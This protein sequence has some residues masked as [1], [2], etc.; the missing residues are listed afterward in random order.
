[1]QACYN[2]T[3]M[4]AHRHVVIKINTYFKGSN[5]LQYGCISIDS[6]MVMPNGRPVQLTVKSWG[7]DEPLTFK[8]SL[9]ISFFSNSCSG[10][11]GASSSG[12]VLYHSIK[13]Q[14]IPAHSQ[15]AGNSNVAP[16]VD[17][18]APIPVPVPV[19]GLVP[20][21]ISGIGVI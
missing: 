5:S 21:P 2:L 17:V 18:P 15:N 14:T 10:N 4:N 1:M 9:S 16:P 19:P 7:Q 20:V 11:S 12:S 3:N 13:S 6:L 8:S